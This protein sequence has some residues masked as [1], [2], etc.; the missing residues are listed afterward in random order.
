MLDTLFRGIF[1]NAAIRHKIAVFFSLDTAKREGLPF[2][3]KFGE[4][5]PFACPLVDFENRQ[6]TPGTG[7]WVNLSYI[8]VLFKQ[9][10][11]HVWADLFYFALHRYCHTGQGIFSL[12]GSES[13]IGIGFQAVIKVFPSCCQEIKPAVIAVHHIDGTGDRVSCLVNGR[14]YSRMDFLYDVFKI[15][16]CL[17]G[18][19]PAH[20]CFRF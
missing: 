19:P 9:S 5:K 20:S 3:G 1:D 16:S 12:H 2:N 4:I 15:I 7:I 18:K 6:H 13:N 8:R 11:Q 14:K 10:G 17:H